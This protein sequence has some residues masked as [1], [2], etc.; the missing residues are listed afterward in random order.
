MPNADGRN[1]DDPFCIAT[2]DTAGPQSTASTGIK[3]FAFSFP[4]LGREIKK[5]KPE[6]L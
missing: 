4:I 6:V 3:A 5:S 1:N 2:V